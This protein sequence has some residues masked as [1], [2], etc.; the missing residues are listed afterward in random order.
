MDYF[1]GQEANLGAGDIKIKDTNDDGKIDEDEV[2]YLGARGIPR[3]EAKR[4][5][6]EGFFDPIMQRIPFEKVRSRLQQ[7]I[8]DKLD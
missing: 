6:V 5:I 8:V 7:A 4:L 2:F 3:E 1:G